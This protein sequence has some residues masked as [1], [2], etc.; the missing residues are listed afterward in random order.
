LP[1]NQP[2]PSQAGRGVLQSED[3]SDHILRPQ[4]STG[5]GREFEGEFHP[6]LIHLESCPAS[7]IALDEVSHLIPD[8]VD[9]TGLRSLY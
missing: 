8:E 5:E 7:G 1:E 2:F 6:G 9:V 4:A 3:G